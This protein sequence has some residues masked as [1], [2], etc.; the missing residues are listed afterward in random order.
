MKRIARKTIKNC[1]IKLSSKNAACFMY[2]FDKL[3]I[4]NKELAKAFEGA[5]L[6][7]YKVD[8]LEMSKS[9]RKCPYCGELHPN[10][11]KHLKEHK[12]T[13]KDVALL[14][15][16]QKLYKELLDVQ[17]KKQTI[18]AFVFTGSGCKM[19]A[20]PIK[21]GREGLCAVPESARNKIRSLKTVGF[22]CDG[23][24]DKWLGEKYGV[25]IIQGAKE[26]INKIPNR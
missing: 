9:T 15:F 12:R 6:W 5:K 21:K 11:K 1:K 24:K 16:Q 14:K 10:L 3:G 22:E 7:V 19:C 25:I 20:N 26:G 18:A 8:K 13:S 2:D 17:R 4:T 23:F